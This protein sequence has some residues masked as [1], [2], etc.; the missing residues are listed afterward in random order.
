ME[1]TFQE[2]ANSDQHD[3]DAKIKQRDA[4]EIQTAAWK[5]VKGFNCIPRD[6]VAK[7]MNSCD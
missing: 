2:S 4:V 6:I 5:W 3:E 1:E 7:L